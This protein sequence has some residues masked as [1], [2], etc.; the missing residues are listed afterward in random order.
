MNGQLPIRCAGLALAC[1]LTAGCGGS[2]SA[3]PGGTM[4]GLPSDITPM[5][6]P[7]KISGFFYFHGSC[8][9]KRLPAAGATFALA[10][11][12]GL[13]LA[14]TIPKNSGQ[15][16]VSITMGDATGQ[17]DITGQVNGQS[18][19][20]YPNPCAKSSCPGTAFMYFFFDS[21]VKVAKVTGDSS[22]KITN[23]GKY[24]GT[25]CYVAFDEFSVPGWAP[26]GT[27]S[28]VPNG[29]RLTI[30]VEFSGLAKG[31]EANTFAVLCV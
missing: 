11:Y 30:S 15:G 16:K 25:T 29:H 5:A 18:F 26:I 8:L 3:M 19:S 28:G 27:F 10:K 31:P 9:K 24:P 6:S 20:A 4:L 14:L 21:S 7:C 12:K 13:T 23:A 1:F 2:P 22:L 17:G